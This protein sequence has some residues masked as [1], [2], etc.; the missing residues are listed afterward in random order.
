MILQLKTT[1]AKLALFGVDWGGGVNL[2]QYFF[3]VFFQDVCCPFTP[4]FLWKT[5]IECLS[6]LFEFWGFLN[7]IFWGGLIKGYSMFW[8][9]AAHRPPFAHFCSRCKLL[10]FKFLSHFI[11]SFLVNVAIQLFVFFTREASQLRQCWV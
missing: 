4:C 6:A 10:V 9:H 7:Y 3:P 11:V 8:L 1:V 5:Y 2:F